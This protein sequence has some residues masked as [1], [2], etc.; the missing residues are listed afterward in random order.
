MYCI[1]QTLNH[2]GVVSHIFK[3]FVINCA[4]V[5]LKGVVYFP[6]GDELND[7]VKQYECMGMPN[8]CGS[9]DVTHVYLKKCPVELKNLCT[10]KEKRPTLAFQCVCQCHVCYYYSCLRMRPSPLQLVHY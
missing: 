9:M 2:K 6:E 5:F 1:I 4:A 10:G 3:T 8:A 7:F